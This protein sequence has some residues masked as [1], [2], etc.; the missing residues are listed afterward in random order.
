ML[1]K[2]F[3]VHIALTALL[4]LMAWKLGA[5]CKMSL[6]HLRVAQ[7]IVFGGPALFFL[8]R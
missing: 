4:G 8:A 7:L 3:V 6:R 1:R 5:T 2:L